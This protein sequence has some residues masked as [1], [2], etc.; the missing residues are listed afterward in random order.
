MVIFVNKDYVECFKKITTIVIAAII[1][2]LQLF[3]INSIILSALKKKKV[4]LFWNLRILVKWSGERSGIY[5][6][7]GWGGAFDLPLVQGYLM[8]N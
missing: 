6:N 3:F 4:A 1:I 2:L 7:G 5:L 8:I